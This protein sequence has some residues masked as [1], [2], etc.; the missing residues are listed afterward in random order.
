MPSAPLLDPLTGLLLVLGLGLMLLQGQQRLGLIATMAIG[1][2]YLIP[3]V[4]SGD[5]PHAMRSLGTLAPAC[6]LAGSGLIA[7]ASAVG[8]WRGG[9][10]STLLAFSLAFNG[11]LYFGVMPSIPGVYQEF[12]LTQT[13]MGRV[14]SAARRSNDPALRTLQIYLPETTYQS[15]SVRYLGWGMATVG[16]YGGAPLP[17]AGDALIILPATA[18]R[19]EQARAMAALGDGAIALGSTAYYPGTG[20]PITLAFG[21]G[22]AAEELVASLRQGQ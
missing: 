9:F 5:A 18:S 20:E 13:S 16:V 17:P 6:L 10:I 1:T 2:I 12:D 4:L 14:L 15:D 3:G 7:L 8:S 22:A 21:R 19:D 11:W